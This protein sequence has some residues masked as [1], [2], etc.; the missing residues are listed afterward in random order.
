MDSQRFAMRPARVLAILVTILVAT[1]GVL[2]TRNLLMSP[3]GGASW[4]GEPATGPGCG[5]VPELV[6]PAIPDPVEFQGGPSILPPL[7]DPSDVVEFE[8]LQDQLPI[9]VPT[10][11]PSDL[12]MQLSLRIDEDLDGDRSEEWMVQLFYGERR[13]SPH[14]ILDNF[15]DEGGTFF[16]QQRS[17]GLDADAALAQLKDQGRASPPV[18]AIGPYEA[19]AIHADPII[20]NDLRPWHLY[21]SD[22]VSDFNIQGDTDVAEL[23]RMGRSL[24]C[25]D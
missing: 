3:L 11:V 5:D 1:A 19:V 13:P 23:V 6:D 24:Y 8:E 20:R 22:G 7:F 25:A 12:P 14:E 16:Q 15:L 4:S 18:V 2:L 17:I 10:S 21:W 9:E